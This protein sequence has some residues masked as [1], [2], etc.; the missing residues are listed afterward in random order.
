MHYPII[1]LSHYPCD[2]IDQRTAI[3]TYTCDTTYY[4]HTALTYAVQRG[5]LANVKLL[6][7]KGATLFTPTPEG[8]S[9]EVCSF[10]F[11]YQVVKLASK[12]PK[13]T[14]KL[15]INASLQKLSAEDLQDLFFLLKENPPS[16]NYMKNLEA[17]RPCFEAATP[18][19]HYPSAP[20]CIEGQPNLPPCAPPSYIEESASSVSCAP[21]SS[22]SVAPHASF[23]TTQ[24]PLEQRQDFFKHLLKLSTED[25]PLNENLA[26]RLALQEFAQNNLA[27]LTEDSRVP[28]SCPYSH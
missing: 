15:K 22:T 28:S 9:P 10:I 14:D 7:K 2:K 1:P 18:I 27:N 4:H 21:S 12:D 25:N 20:L 3:L 19:E 23:F 11:I 16:L 13:S 8:G 24:S 6:L 17:F 5:R 26:L